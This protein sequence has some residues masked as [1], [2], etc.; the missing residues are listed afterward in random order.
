MLDCY[1]TNLYIDIRHSKK[2]LSQRQ[3]NKNYPDAATGDTVI[4]TV[5]TK[6]GMKAYYFVKS[7]PKSWYK[8]KIEEFKKEKGEQI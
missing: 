7:F 8:S 5:T 2:A 4:N 6:K 3:L 1:S